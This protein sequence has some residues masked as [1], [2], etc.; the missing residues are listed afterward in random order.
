VVKA[1]P[2]ANRQFNISAFAA[3][4]LIFSVGQGILLLLSF[5]QSLIVPK[6]LSVESYGYLQL[7][8]LYASYVG[9]LALGFIEGAF[10]RW[11]GKK[12]DQVGSELKAAFEF[13]VVELAAIIVPLTL[14]SYFLLKPPFQGVALLLLVYAFVFDLGFLFIFAAQAAKRFKLLTAVNVAKG[15]VLLLLIILLFITGHLDYYPVIFALIAS[16]LLFIFVLSFWFRRYFGSKTASPRPLWAYGKENIHIGTFVLL[17][18]LVI[19]LFLT[20]DRLAVSS[21]FPIEQ[22]ATYAF[23]IAV[24]M[25]AYIF[26]QAVSGVFFPYLSTAAHELRARVYQLGKPTIIIAWAGILLAYFP[27]VRLV[28]LYLPHYIAS[29]PLI[30]ILLCTVGFGSLIQILHASYYMT[31]RKQRQYFLCGIAALAMLAILVFSAIKIWGTLESVAIATLIGFSIWYIINEVSLKSVVGE[32]NRELWKS[33]GIICCYL[34]AFLLSSQVTDHVWVQM[35][36]YICLFALLTWLLFRH[37][38]MELA[39]IAREITRRQ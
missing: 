14:L 4:V 19:T 32:S 5:I 6:Y 17:G 18:N 23:A 24:V 11:A 15:L 20:I 27:G 33:F 7:F 36:I 13:L 26:I 28:R 3:D 38:I 9:I 37:T 30:Q 12:P 1:E 25:V 2:S 31:Y 29:L 10:V 22:F 39:K 35:I 21:L 34:G 16:Q 8:V